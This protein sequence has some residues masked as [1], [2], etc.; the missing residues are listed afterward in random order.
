[1]LSKDRPSKG[2]AST[3]IGL[4]N[5]E[6]FIKKVYQKQDRFESHEKFMDKL[7]NDYGCRYLVL[8]SLKDETT[9]DE[10]THEDDSTG[11]T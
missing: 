6:A 2:P 4:R 5:M 9:E 8:K 10:S 3:P 11:K 1:M 7:L